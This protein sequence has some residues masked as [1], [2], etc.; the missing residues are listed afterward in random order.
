MTSSASFLSKLNGRIKFLIFMLGL[1]VIIALFNPALTINALNYFIVIL[2]KIMPILGLVFIILFGTNLFL[3]PEK[4]RKHLGTDS[5]L[6]GWFYAIIDGIIISGPPYVLYPMLGELK[7]HGARNALIATILYNRNVKIHFVPA[8]IYYFGIR[9]TIVL[10][11]YILLFS[12]LNGKLV[13]LLVD[14]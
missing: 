5:G 8:M 13:E 11:V 10:S 12:L 3:N 1:Y 7:N 6:R 14:E 4:I 9:Y 2:A